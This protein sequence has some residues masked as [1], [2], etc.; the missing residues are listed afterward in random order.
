MEIKKKLRGAKKKIDFPKVSKSSGFDK[1][2]SDAEKQLKQEQL[3]I[4]K[5]VQSNVPE[6]DKAMRR[7]DHK[8]L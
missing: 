2:I 1:D 5:C 3:Q 6:F 8:G 7:K 4:V